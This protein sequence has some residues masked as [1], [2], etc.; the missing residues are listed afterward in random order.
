MVDVDHPANGTTVDDTFD[1]DNP[2]RVTQH[3]THAQ[4]CVVALA[5]VYDL[6]TVILCCLKDTLQR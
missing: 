3:V 6:E 4:D 5:R 1:G 2:G